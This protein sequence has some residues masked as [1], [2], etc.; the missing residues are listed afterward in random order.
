MVTN[1]GKVRILATSLLASVLPYAWELIFETSFSESMP[2]Q[3]SCS[4]TGK[5]A[6]SQNHIH[7]AESH[8]DLRPTTR[9]ASGIKAEDVEHQYY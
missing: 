2:S 5:L 8:I 1:L 4:I 9:Y 6:I 7:I 3:A